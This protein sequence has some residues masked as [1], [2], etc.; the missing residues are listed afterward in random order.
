M[1]PAIAATLERAS[2]AVRDEISDVSCAQSDVAKNQPPLPLIKSVRSAR[3]YSVATESER[4]E[5][6]SSERRGPCDRNHPCKAARSRVK[7]HQCEEVCN[8]LASDHPRPRDAR[9]PRQRSESLRAAAPPPRQEPGVCPPRPTEGPNAT[10]CPDGDD[11]R[12]LSERWTERPSV[13]FC[14]DGIGYST[15]GRF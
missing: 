11:L 3:I 4:T 5:Q 6:D 1:T 14:P 2:A 9:P 15:C 10:C 12:G 7:G 13:T 8:A